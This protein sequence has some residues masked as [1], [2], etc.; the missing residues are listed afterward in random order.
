MTCAR[1]RSRTRSSSTRATSRTAATR[2][3]TE[4]RSNVEDSDSS[5]SL[6]VAGM[7]R[8]GPRERQHPGVRPQRGRQVAELLPR[9]DEALLGPVVERAPGV[10]VDVDVDAFVLAVD[11]DE[12]VRELADQIGLAGEL[13]SLPIAEIVVGLDHPR[14]TALA[15][16]DAHLHGAVLA[17][18]LHAP[19]EVVAV[20]VPRHVA[21]VEHVAQREQ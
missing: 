20:L 4:S 5:M 16:D 19:R 2:S 12:V 13:A 21:R 14:A 18:Q 7:R 9:I 3:A 6:H 8:L 17:A 1:T 15:I 11:L 10:G